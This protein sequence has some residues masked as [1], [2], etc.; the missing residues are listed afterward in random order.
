M[1]LVY[2]TAACKNR[3]DCMT[4]DVVDVRQVPKPQRHPLIFARFSGL[5]IGEALVVVN[6]HDPRH[7]REEFER[8]QPGRFTWEYLETGPAAWRVRIGRRS[9]TALPSVLCN[10]YAMGRD[11]AAGALWKLEMGER[12]LDANIIR[13][14]AEGHIASHPGPDLDVLLFVVDRAGELITNIGSAPLQPGDLAWLPR[15]SERSFRA[16]PQGLSYLTVHPRR[17]ALQIAAAATS[18][19]SLPPQERSPHRSS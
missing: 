8:E 6:S 17:A 3:M 14:R 19:I 9:A 7:L 12:H 11:E 5:A 18:E 15:G 13:M 2:T 16:G 10:V 1:A 4:A